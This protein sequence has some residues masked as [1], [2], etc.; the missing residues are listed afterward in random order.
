[1][2]QRT[3]LPRLLQPLLRNRRGCPGHRV[4][5]HAN[6]IKTQGPLCECCLQN[7]GGKFAEEEVSVFK[8]ALEK[9]DSE[10]QAWSAEQA[11]TGKGK[12]WQQPHTVWCAAHRQR[13]HPA[14][15]HG[16]SILWTPKRFW[17]IFCWSILWLQNFFVDFCW[18]ILWFQKVVGQIFIVV[19]RQN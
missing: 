11:A 14:T 10:A 6:W 1:M 17:S 19:H 12:S 8:K 18:S 2:K 3:N 9:T 7:E 15:R 5:V 16:W 4:C 13:C